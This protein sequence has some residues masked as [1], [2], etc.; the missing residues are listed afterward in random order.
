MIALYIIVGERWRECA[1]L[2]G[3]SVLRTAFALKSVHCTHTH[4]FQGLRHGHE[5]YRRVAVL[6]CQSD[7]CN[8]PKELKKATAFDPTYET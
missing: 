3:R 8:W 5:N 1:M 4:A 6:T 2:F 7:F